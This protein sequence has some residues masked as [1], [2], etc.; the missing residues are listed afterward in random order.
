MTPAW[1]RNLTL[2]WWCADPHDYRFKVWL[3]AEYAPVIARWID[4]HRCAG[5]AVVR[6]THALFLDVCD[7][8]QLEPDHHR[9]DLAALC[10]RLAGLR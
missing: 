7:W 9:R 1:F 6:Q 4:G 8:S 3:L 10:K 5:S 2:E